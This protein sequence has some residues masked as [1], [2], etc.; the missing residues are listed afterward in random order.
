MKR[1]G[2]LS[3][4]QIQGVESGD[5]TLEARLFRDN[6]TDDAARRRRWPGMPVWAQLKVTVMGAEY[7]QAGGTW[8]KLIY[9][10]TNP[11][12]RHVRW[13]NMAHSPS[14][15]RV[16]RSADSALV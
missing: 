10:S 8:G 12:W 1:Q 6:P 9:G 4:Y 13:T 5:T 2:L 14:T 15:R 16:K 11:A 7:R 3:T